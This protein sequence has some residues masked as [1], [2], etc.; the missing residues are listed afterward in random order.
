MKCT[1][2]GR[3]L[4]NHTQFITATSI[5]W[6]LKNIKTSLLISVLILPAFVFQGCHLQTYIVAKNEKIDNGIKQEVHALDDKLFKA[7]KTNDAASLKKMMSS[8]LTG[9]NNI[10]Q[11]IDKIDSVPKSENYKILDEY[12]V[13]NSTTGIPGTILS[14]TSSKNEYFIHYMAATK[15]TYVALLTTNIPNSEMLITAIYGKYGN[16]WKLNSLQFGTYTVLNKTPIDLFNLAKQYYDKSYLIDAADYASLSNILLKPAGNLLQYKSEDEIRSF[17]K[18]VMQEV[19]NKYQF[20]LTISNIDSKPEIFSIY[21]ET[22]HGFFPVIK[23]L[24]AINLKDTVALKNENE[25]I[26]KEIGQIF[27]GIAEN[28]EYVFYQACNKMPHGKKPT[29]GYNFVDRMTKPTN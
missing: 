29:P 14:G 15:E 25:K 21:P 6:R 27:P 3:P 22:E 8:A 1:T 5:L 12:Y 16:D 23:Y 13:E 11:F 28:K 7:W 9:S 20:P 19:K 17:Y 24:S 10:D 4:I 18:K 2:S 26:K